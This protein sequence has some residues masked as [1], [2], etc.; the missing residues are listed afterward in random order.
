[1]MTSFIMTSAP[2]DETLAVQIP[3][4]NFSYGGPP[5]LQDINLQLPRGA[6]CLLVGANGTGKTTL[7]RIL[8]GKRMVKD[9][10]RV[11]GK[12][13]FVDAPLG[14]TYLGTE[15]AANPVV[16]SDLRV[17]YLLQSMGG[18]RW[19]KRRDEL[20]D[21]L[22]VNIN[23]RM[24]QVSD[25]E[26]RRV[27]LVMGL[28]QPWDLL[29]LDEVTVDLDVLVR[30]DFLEHLKKETEER[31][32]HTHLRW[33]DPV[34]VWIWRSNASRCP[35]KFIPCFFVSYCPGLGQWPSHI[36]H[37]TQGTIVSLNSLHSFPELELFKQ[38]NREHGIFDSPLVAL[39]L[40][41]LRQDRD[42]ERKRKRGDLEAP[43]ESTG[44]AITRWDE[45]SEDMKKYGDRY[46]N[47]W[48]T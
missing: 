37:M 29:L 9:E 42:R 47:Y 35:M 25:G 17:D 27:Q 20:L 15:W 34:S 10:V 14:V 31:L 40:S 26:R 32:R 41:W 30:S 23:W 18:H 12:N 16:R 1:M 4:L 21:V 45:L 33:Y 46:Y 43:L 11:L 38:Y 5:I 7:L 6:R 39:C 3:T 13:A 22:D 44:K 36:G 28:M 24:H 19:P 8:A 2:F 48:K